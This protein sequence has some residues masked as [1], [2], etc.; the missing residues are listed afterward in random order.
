MLLG[1]D[2]GIILKSKLEMDCRGTRI[3]M[4]KGRVK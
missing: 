3:Q 1:L 4:Y 2:K